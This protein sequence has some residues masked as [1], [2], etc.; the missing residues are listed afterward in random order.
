MST[1]DHW[2]NWLKG[3]KDSSVSFILE[4]ALRPKLERYGRLIRLKIDSRAKTATIEILPKGETDS[5]TVWVERYELT[6]KPAGTYLIVQRASA[7]REWLTL[8]M[9]DLLLGRSWLVPPQYATYVKLA[10]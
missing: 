8:L 10:I 4:K 1:A 5:I 6:E 2:K 7:S 3:H 9:E